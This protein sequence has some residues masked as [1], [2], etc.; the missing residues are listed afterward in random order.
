MDVVADPRLVE[1]RLLGRT[2][3]FLLFAGLWGDTA[4][5]CVTKTV[6]EP[7]DALARAQLRAEAQVLALLRERPGVARVL[8][9]DSAAG[10]LVLARAPGLPLGEALAALSR[11]EV[12]VALSRADARVALSRDVARWTRVGLALARILDGVHR[13]GVLHG[14]LHP[15]NILFDA[16]SGEVTLI[17]FGAAV[18]QGRIDTDFR[19][20]AQLGRALP[21]GAPELT[22]RLGRAADFRADHY[23]LGAVLYALLCGHPPFVEQEPLALLHALLTRL[24]PPLH[25]LAPDVPAC[26][27]AVVAK[28]LA[29]Q[30]EQRYQSAQ[31]LQADLHHCVEVAEGLAQGIE[32]ADDAA[33]LPGRHDRRGR[34][35]LPSRLFGREAAIAGLQAALRAAPGQARLAV[36]HGEAGAGKTSLVRAALA[37]VSA[38][39]GARDNA[40]EGADAQADAQTGAQAGAQADAQIGAQAD[41]QAD[42]RAGGTVF[43]SAAF[44]Q[45]RLDQPY[46]A[47]ADLLGELAEYWLCEPPAVLGRLREALR[48]AVGSN[49]GLLRLVAPAFAPLLPLAAGAAADDEPAASPGRLAVDLNGR[50]RQALAAVFGVLRRHAG[51][52][53]L[54]VD[55]LQWADAHSL[56]LLEHLA[57]EQSRDTLLLVVAYRDDEADALHPLHGML[58]RVSA[59]GTRCVDIATGALSAEVVAALVADVLDADAPSVV[60]LAHALHRKTGG[61]AFF[62]LQHL[63]R[64]FDDGQLSRSAAG[65]QWDPAALAALPEREKLV[66]GLIEQLRRLPAPVQRVAAVCACLGNPIDEPLLPDVLGITPEQVDALLLP[67]LQHEMLLGG[68]G[69]AGASV[70][71]AHGAHGARRLRFC[72]DRM[73]QAA[74]ELL[75]PAER[76]LCH[77]SIARALMRRG[78]TAGSSAHAHSGANPGASANA[79]IG[80]NANA[81]TGAHANA[82]AD[83]HADAQAGGP[84]P[85][86]TGGGHEGGAARFA[87]AEHWLAALDVLENDAERRQALDLLLGAGRAAVE[88]GA[89]ATAERFGD[90]AASLVARG[91]A[92]AAQ[93]LEATQT[94]EAAL[95]QHGA[96]F[97]L[98]RYDEADRV[99]AG[100]GTLP[101]AGPA[102]IA[103]AT[104]RQCISLA[105]RGRYEEATRLTLDAARQLGLPCPDDDAW[106]AA[107]AAEVDAFYAALAVRG[108]GLFDAL[109]PLDD[110]ATETAAFMLVSSFAAAAYWRPVISHWSKMRVLRLGFE[111]GRFAA[112]PE[113]LVLATITLIHLRDDVATGYALAHAGLRLQQHYPSA[114]LRA[115]SHFCLAGVNTH[116]FEPL[117]RCVEHTRL[118]Y[119]WA[120]EAGDTECASMAQFIGMAPALDCTPGLEDML[121]DIALALQVTERFGDRGSSD[122]IRVYR[123]FVDCLR[124]TAR[125]PGTWP[126]SDPADPADAADAA[127]AVVAANPLMQALTAV[128]RAYAAALFGDWPAALQLGRDGAPVVALLTGTYMFA[129]GR[130]IHALALGHALRDSLACERDALQAELEPLAAWL[131]RRAADAPANF[132]HC[133]ELLCAVRAWAAG[134]PGAAA[135]RFEA[136]LDSAQR[137]HRPGH[138]ALA[139]EL[140]A[141]F[142]AAQGVRRAASA[143]RAAALRA[144]EEWGATAKLAQRRAQPPPGSPVSASE[145]STATLDIDSL[146]R[147]GDLL[148]QERD[149]RALLGVLFELLRQY[150]AADRGVL[151]WRVGDEWVARAGFEPGRTWFALGGDAQPSGDAALPASVLHSLTHAPR[152]L[153]LPDVARHA[154]FGT[155]PHVLRHGVKSIVGLPISLHGQP[156]CLLYLENRQAHTTLAPQQLGTLRLIGLQFAAA[157]ENA[158]I[159]RELEAL[160]ASRTAEL[161]R[162]RNAWEAMLQHAPAIVFVKDLEG[163]YLSHTPQLA[164]LLGRPGQSLLG[165]SDAV[166]VEP[167]IAAAIEAQDRQVIHEGQPLRFEQQRDSALGRRSYLTHKFPLRDALGKVY[168]V[169]GMSIDITE[170]K[171]AQRTAEAATQAKSDFLANM[172]HEIRTPMNAIVGMSQL[173]LSAEPARQRDFIMKVHASAR[174]LDRIIDDI[175]DFSKIEAGKIDL[176]RVPFDLREVLDKLA[177]VVGLK[178]QEK[179]LALFFDLHPDVPTVLRGDALRLGQVLINLCNNAVKF[180]ERGEI[181]VAIALR[182]RDAQAATLTFEVRDSGIGMSPAQVQQVF[183]PFQQADASTS[184]RYGGTGL[185]LTIS[186]RLVQLMGGDITVASEPGRGSTLSFALRYALHDGPL[187]RAEQ[188]AG[189]TPADVRAQLAGLRVLL[190]EDHPFNREL[191]QE[192]LRRVGIEVRVAEHGAQALEILANERFDGVL[193]DCQMP[194]MDGYA[195][196]RALRAQ[197]ALRDLPVIALTANAMVGEHQRAIAAGMND[198]IT[199]PIEVERL[200]ATLARWLRPETPPAMPAEEAAVEAAEPADATDP[201]PRIDVRA[202]LKVAAGDPALYQRL[203]RVFRTTCVELPARLDRALAGGDHAAVR[204]L[205]HK[206]KGA[207]V[208]VGAAR[209]PHAA[210]ALGRACREGANAASIDALHAALA[211]ELQAVVGEL[212]ALDREHSAPPG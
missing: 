44:P 211:G 105:N 18:V 114:R 15:D 7:G 55:D 66:A 162:N 19:H 133:W 137:H 85:A 121:H 14:D 199:K 90:A 80:A 45:F 146:L 94:L 120:V 8:H 135:P 212:A 34:P 20:A 150:A 159:G 151:L 156:L 190:V 35:A 100:L 2:G 1:A 186:R 152:P 160:V 26:L 70:V 171:Q 131:E 98:A 81:H 117:E 101:A 191:A 39:E 103:E 209:L 147:A 163:R 187:P 56:D 111:R 166:L 181:D 128:Y 196:T 36:V 122:A 40:G 204:E 28:L 88:R 46:G 139:C 76:S 102:R 16:P 174:A 155:D 142:H 79:H 95:L 164:E 89:F 91:C 21:F 78:A 158:R 112:L 130:W 73:L 10:V 38:G 92:G 108:P 206:L 203:L 84:L 201:L 86:G 3:G 33:F 62:V 153:L 126:E 87:L 197:P 11:A 83:A 134:D 208:T 195:A 182:E 177:T 64:L 17:D 57:I 99:Y 184:R 32:P 205:C 75:P 43:A 179:G 113:A 143:Y 207:A 185:G 97:G 71:G 123:R 138:Y 125:A 25:T 124:D 24:P 68:Q 127:D 129:L 202:G 52:L 109:A 12:P 61:N 77:R 118:A 96:Y 53:L 116:W 145:G 67:L 6:A 37:R 175:L 50:L 110:P 69:G 200:Y 168:G 140:A 41:A 115:R 180:T 29:K 149:P 119:R 4:T 194:V 30:P 144:F 106:D 59:A 169:G 154:R 161:Q 93:A 42:A 58:A 192:L 27:S 47:L 104:A 170:L 165:L 72:H 176:E 157:Y 63:Q 167:H 23:A 51:A 198:H 54:F 193:M 172:S 132:A 74:H 183:Q 22:G 31:G 65:W 49:A 173:A 82:H 188:T 136:A 210:E 9:F 141:A 5:P 178:A 107:L 48:E 60:A 189:Q 148:S 13:A